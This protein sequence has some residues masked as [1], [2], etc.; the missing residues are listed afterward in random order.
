MV[1]HMAVED[2]LTEALSM[3]DR[4]VVVTA[5]PD[6]RKGEQI[7]VCYTEDAGSVETLQAAIKA[8]SI[9]NLW[10]PKKDNY[11]LIDSIPTLGTGKL[12]LK[13]IKEIAREF[14]EVRPGRIQR[15]VSKLKGK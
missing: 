6:E 12:D 5:A 4:C 15:A 14:V 13:G 8:S 2:V 3:V 7:V 9:P 10:K 11:I 1:P